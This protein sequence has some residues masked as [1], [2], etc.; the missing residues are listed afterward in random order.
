[1]KFTSLTYL[2]FLPLVFALHW[3]AS[4][5]KRQNAVLV[6]ASYVFY[7]WWDWRFC[8]LMAA[9][10]LVDFTVAGRLDRT[11]QPRLRKALLATSVGVN[12]G[13]LGFFKY[14]NFFAESAQTAAAQ[15]G[16]NMHPVTL[17]VILPVG[18]SFYTFQTMSY[19]IDVYR[20]RMPAARSL[21]DYATYLSFFPQ[22]VAG[23]IERGQRLLPQFQAPRRFDV[24]QAEDGARQMLWGVVKKMLIADQ[25][26]RVADRIYT[27]PDAFT[28]PQLAFGTL[29][30]AFQIYCDFSAYSDIAIGTAR[31]FGVGLMRNFAHPYLSQSLGEFWRRWHISLSTWFRDYVYIPL[32]GGRAGRARRATNVMVTFLLSGLW[33]GASWNFVIWGGINGAGVLPEVLSP[34]RRTRRATEIPLGEGRWPGPR[35][36]ARVALTFS[37]VTLAWVFFRATDLPQALDILRTI[38]TDSLRPGAW[39]PAGLHKAEAATAAL[40]IPALIAIEWVTRARAH[41]FEAIRGWPRGLRWALYTGLLWATLYLTPPESNPFIYFQF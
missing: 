31:L 40:L 4:D 5:R 28:G 25:L 9:S 16:W 29:C 36:L 6:F 8:G 23:P 21:L 3:S 12:L 18:I 37:V 7:G 27:T 20:R 11:T 19:A 33:H 14:F 41:P 22:L 35:A 1:L 10:T 15:V 26:A 13:I 17:K 24:E 34:R 2:L 38:A 39:T 32:G 30:F